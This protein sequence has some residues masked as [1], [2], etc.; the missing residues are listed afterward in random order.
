MKATL[1][2]IGILLVTAG[3]VAAQNY[4]GMSR[5]KVEKSIGEPDKVGNNF[6]VYSDLF[7]GGDNIYYFDENDFCKS[8]ELVRNNSYLRTYK[9]M[10]KNEFVEGNTNIYFTRM[11][12]K[13]YQAELVLL[14]NS[15]QIKIQNVC[16]MQV[17]DQYPSIA[18]MLAK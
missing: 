8:F 11:K 1:I 14:K 4:I 10:L 12:N 2:I 15:F 9:R 16:E 7:E 3:S 18:Q 5:N 6:Y 13:Y 17:N